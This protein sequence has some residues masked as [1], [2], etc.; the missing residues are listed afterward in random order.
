MTNL[1][2]KI[3][4]NSVVEEEE[5]EE[6]GEAGEEELVE[7]DPQ[8]K[9]EETL[10]TAKKV[11][12]NKMMENTNHSEVKEGVALV[13]RGGVDLGVKGEALVESEEEGLVEKDVALEKGKDLEGIGREIGKALEKDKGLVKG[14]DLEM[15]VNRLVKEKALVVDL[16]N[17]VISKKMALDEEGDV[18][19]QDQEEEAG[20]EVEEAVNLTGIVAVTEGNFHYIL[21]PFPSQIYQNKFICIGRL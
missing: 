11:M 8:G 18:D 12:I 6:G 19:F 20:E 10:V 14:K 5:A 21:P 15:I 7:T 4:E 9:E 1:K 3:E 16:V 17:K 2:D 13:V